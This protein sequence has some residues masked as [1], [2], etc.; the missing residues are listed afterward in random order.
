MSTDIQTGAQEKPP[1]TPLSVS[2]DGTDEDRVCERTATWV[3]KGPRIGVYLFWLA[4]ALLAL[5]VTAYIGAI[6]NRFVV[7]AVLTALWLPMTYFLYWRAIS[8][9]IIRWHVLK[10]GSPVKNRLRGRFLP[11]ALSAIFSAAA[12]LALFVFASQGVSLSNRVALVLAVLLWVFIEPTTT[13]VVERNTK[14]YA[15]PYFAKRLTY[16]T[17]VGAVSLGLLLVGF[18]EPHPD[19]TNLTAREAFVFGQSQA[20]GQFEWIRFLAG[21]SNGLDYVCIWIAQT[22]SL[23]QDNLGLTLGAWI[24]LLFKM[25]AFVI[26][27][28]LLIQ[29]ASVW[30]TQRA[31]SRDHK[32]DARASV[33]QH[34]INAASCLVAAALMFGFIWDQA[35]ANP[36]GWMTGQTIT[37]SMSGKVYQL[38]PKDLEA[39]LAMAQA[40]TTITQNRA[41]GELTDQTNQRI[42]DVFDAAIKRVPEY[43]D[44]HF[45]MSGKFTAVASALPQVSAKTA[46]SIL[47][48][49]VGLDAQLQSIEQGYVNQLDFERFAQASNWSR[50]LRQSL[51]RFES[52]ALRNNSRP[53]Q[54]FSPE[55][56]VAKSQID[57][58]LGRT[59]AL[60]EFAVSSG[61][62]VAVTGGSVISRRKV[63]AEKTPPN[64]GKKAVKKVKPK[65]KFSMKTAWS[66][67]LAS[68]KQASKS[69]WSNAKSWGTATKTLLTKDGIK[70]AGSSIK[71]LPGA[72][73]KLKKYAPAIGRFAAKRA[74]RLAVSPGCGPAAIPCAI[75]I[76]ASTE[77]VAWY[78]ATRL[79]KYQNQDALEAK[80]IA[81]LNRSRESLKRVYAARSQSALEPNIDALTARVGRA[82]MPVEYF[83][84]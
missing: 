13:R 12:A 40:K 69:L 30:A 6:G 64:N 37:F 49:T 46:E 34:L 4:L 43:A 32:S 71:S 24:V 3:Q 62:A 7:G 11:L 60:T 9:R 39:S 77:A 68:G 50:N 83:I 26:S 57:D 36:W 63:A 44:Q 10:E 2:N 16:W 84:N 66:K 74:P 76:F 45:S 14:V 42:D 38:S 31:T 1:Q 51:E 75:V 81:R 28:L 5:H 61:F 48:P 27:A 8:R 54:P 80:M 15:A 47:F 79:D 22:M 72:A 78:G 29:A 33:S 18:F 25:L 55:T 67:M 21:L 70:A 23:V 82:V 52:H 58:L 56:I 35:V 53:V 65:N 19:L 59:R 73:L 41:L 17:V 20:I